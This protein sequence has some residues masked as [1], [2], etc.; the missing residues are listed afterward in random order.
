MRPIAPI[1]Y[2]ASERFDCVKIAFYTS[3]Y[4]ALDG[5]DLVFTLLQ[6]K[7]IF[8]KFYSQG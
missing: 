5:F 4:N 3:E 2:L 7:I 6:N 1:Q 8:L